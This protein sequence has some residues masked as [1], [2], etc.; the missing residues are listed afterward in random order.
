MKEKLKYFWIILLCAGCASSK[1]VGNTPVIIEEKVVEKTIIKDSIIYKDSI[2]YIPQE[3]VV[4]VTPQLDTLKMEIEVAEAKAYLDNTN[5][6][7]R[8]ELKSK[9][10]TQKEIV[11]ITKIVEKVDSVFIDKPTPYE[12]KVEVPYIPTIYKYSLWF[13]IAVMAFVFGR[14]LMKI[15]RLI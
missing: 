5:M 11:E 3:K 9:K 2:V 12:V 8:G 4:N 14:L 1:K 13:S 7:L 15:K 10:A 6:T